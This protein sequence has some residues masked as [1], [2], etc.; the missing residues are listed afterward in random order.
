METFNISSASIPISHSE[1][2]PI[3][4]FYQPPRSQEEEMEENSTFQ[5]LQEFS[6]SQVSNEFKC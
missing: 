5:E 4:V 6:A 2:V 3:T 1:D